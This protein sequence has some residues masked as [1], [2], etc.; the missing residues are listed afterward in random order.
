MRPVSPRGSSPA[1]LQWYS[2]PPAINKGER[3]GRQYDRVEVGIP[4]VFAAGPGVG[5]DVGNRT[6]VF[7][8][9]VWG[10]HHRGDL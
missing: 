5:F 9:F 8:D 3:Y 1:S 7:A 10:W 4:G 2:K 6:G